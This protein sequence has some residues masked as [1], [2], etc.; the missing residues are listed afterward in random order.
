MLGHRIEFLADI[1][2]WIEK[3]PFLKMCRLDD[4]F[5]RLGDIVVA[6][7]LLIGVDDHRDRVVADHRTG[8]IGSQFPLR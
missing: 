8:V 6:K 3:A 1:C 7:A 5:V 4:G 2:G